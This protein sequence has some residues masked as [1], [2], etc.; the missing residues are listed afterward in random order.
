MTSNVIEDAKPTILVVDDE[1]TL[2]FAFEATFQAEG[3]HVKSACDGNEAIELLKQGGYDETYDVMTLDLRMPGMDG[4]GVMERLHSLGKPVPTLLTSAH[5]DTSTAV[6]AAYYG[7][8][9]FLKKPSTPAE[10]RSAVYDLMEDRKRFDSD[11]EFIPE[12]D[13]DFVRYAKWKVR[14]GNYGQALDILDKVD[15]NGTEKSLGPWTVIIS[16]LDAIT[17]HGTRPPKFASDNFYDAADL[18]DQVALN[19]A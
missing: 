14:Q 18:L 13:A 4:L 17:E 16:H 7:V 3:F 2:T 10:L 1:P 5:M 8:V 19:R 11:T 6:R 9:D 12:N 15:P